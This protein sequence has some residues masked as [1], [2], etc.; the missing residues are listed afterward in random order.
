MKMSSQPFE[1]VHL[2]LAR[3]KKGGTHF[4]VPIDPD[5]AMEFKKGK[6]IDVR[7][8]VQSEDVFF[9]AQ[10]GELVSREELR[11]VFGTDETLEAI[12]EIIREGEIQ[13]TSEYRKKMKDEKRNKVLNMI[14]KNSVD[15][16]TGYPHPMTRIENAFEEARIRIDEYR[17]AE[18]QVQPILKKL[19]PL[20]PIKFEKKTVEVTL[21][22]QYAGKSYSLVQSY[23]DVKE[24]T[25]NSDG[26]W[27]CKG[28]IPGGM[29]NEF[30]EKINDVTHGN[31]ECKER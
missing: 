3:M 24:D 16:K 20:L 25:W 29:T 18:E 21:P 4:E 1:R 7:E 10:K 23:L 8:M 31:V 15:P 26:S 12:K 14:H 27:T 9:D 19:K 5:L 2:N 11:K 17:T 28:E 22:A 6:D 13:L 30:Y